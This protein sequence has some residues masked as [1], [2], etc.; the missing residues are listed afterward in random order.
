MQKISCDVLV[1]GGGPAG[2]VS[3]VTA[4]MNHPNKKILVV[5]EQEVQLVPCA[6][7]YVFGKT[8]GCSEKDVSSCAMAEEMGISTLV[9][10]VKDIDINQKTAY[11]CDNKISFE[12]LI[13]ATGSTPFVHASLEH[14]LELEG[15]FTIAKNKT[16]IDKL[17][18]YA[19]D[20]KEIVIV[21]SGFIGVEVALEFASKGK[22][23]TVIGG[24]KHILQNAFDLEVAE[25]AEELM[26]EAGVKYI[27][28][29]RVSK[30]IDKNGDNIVNAVEL[31]SGKIVDTQIV[32][33][34]T[35]YKPNTTL[36][37]KSGISLGYYG[38]I[39]VDEYMRT[40]N[41]DV[42]AVGDCSSRRDFITKEP[43]KVMLASTSSA[44]GRIAGTSLYGI[45]YLKGF[46]GT[47]AIFSTMLNKTAFASAGVTEDEA[48][49]ANI[50]VVVGTFSGVNRHPATIPGAHKQFVKLIAMKHGGQIIG[51]QIVGGEE[52]G[53]MINIV[54]HIIESHHDVYKVMSM[55]VATQPMLT[56]APT[57]YPIVMAS[58]VI[59]QKIKNI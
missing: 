8:L 57:S 9:G 53:E 15:V 34:A 37:K 18:A 11:C 56:A 32:I 13:F 19:K 33:L 14:S 40:Q 31:K 27:G 1:I 43:S 45:E 12:K 6:I 17:D 23:V 22:N 10:E 26:L 41:H 21:G 36:A 58:V 42:F 35:G 4:K 54:G 48:K 50:D 29:D 44:E 30:I 47:I 5:R 16:F 46:S 55:Q 51:G 49:A 3:A 38:G 24:S 52:A 59:V 25:Q 28:K 39:W 20:K 2:G 7:P